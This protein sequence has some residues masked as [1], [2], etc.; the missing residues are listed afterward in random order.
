VESDEFGVSMEAVENKS[1]KFEMVD[2]FAE[3][4]E[5]E[6]WRGGGV[7]AKVSESG[8]SLGNRLDISCLSISSRISMD[9]VVP[10]L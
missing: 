7:E 3:E 5:K 9:G 6:E 8:I 4:K 1:D 10:E 2:E